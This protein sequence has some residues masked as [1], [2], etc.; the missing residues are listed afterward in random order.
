MVNNVLPPDVTL[1][2]P[3]PLEVLDFMDIRNPLIFFPPYPFNVNVI[4][5][6]AVNWTLLLV[7]VFTNVAV[8][9]PGSSPVTVTEFVDAT[10]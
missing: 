9:V 1:N 3:A 7:Y 5:L 8:T 6:S 10:V 2:D 4:E